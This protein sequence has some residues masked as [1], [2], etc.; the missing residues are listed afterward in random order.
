MIP[1]YIKVDSLP[2]TIVPETNVAMDGHPILTFRYFLFRDVEAN[3]TVS[4][5]TKLKNMQMAGT[6]P[7]YF[8][9]LTF[10]QP[11][12]M[13]TYTSN[14]KHELATEEV[15]QVIEQITYYREHPELWKEQ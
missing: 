1:I 7:N 6:N 2:L 8:G 14:E 12:Q 5:A 15:E 3:G 9:H 10:D 13:F 11:G 4:E